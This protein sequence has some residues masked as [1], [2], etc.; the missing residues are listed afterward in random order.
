MMFGARGRRWVSPGVAV[1]ALALAVP[2]A[3]SAHDTYVNQEIGHDTGND[4]SQQVTPCK[5]LARGL[6]QVGAGDTVFVAGDSTYTHTIDLTKSESLVHKNFGG[7]TGPAILDNSGAG[8]PDVT[9]SSPTTVQGFTIRS[10]D[11]PVDM[12]VG[13]H[14]IDDRFDTPAAVPEEILSEGNNA[15]VVV[16]NC[17]FIDPTP[18]TDSGAMQMAIDA[19]SV[20]GLTVRKSSFTGFWTAIRTN[21]P[22]GSLE[23]SHSRFAKT[24]DLTTSAGG[25]IFVRAASFADIFDNRLVKPQGFVAGIVSQTDSQITANVVQ[26]YSVGIAINDTSADNYLAADAVLNQGK[27]ATGIQVLDYDAPDPQRDATIDHVTVWGPGEAIE[28]QKAQVKIESSILG[29]EGIKPLYA[30]DS[31]RI[32]HSRGPVRHKGGTGCKNFKTTPRTRS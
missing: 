16:R 14:F 30:N 29:G 5:T 2:A 31:C 4:C 12:K 18:L 27:H 9:V 10:D 11:L 3:A 21:S 1:A 24:H 19:E 8:Q 6:G 22:H 26:G 7:A 17:K 32:S 25:S 20:G 28:L 13:G 15:A 23:V